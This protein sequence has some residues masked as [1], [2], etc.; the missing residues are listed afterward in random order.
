G[1][2][3]QGAFGAAWIAFWRYRV[4][5]RAEPVAAPL[6]DVG[7][8]IEQAVGTW[9]RMP[10]DFWSRLPASR[11]VGKRFGRSVAPWKEC[12]FNSTACGAFP[13]GF[14]RQTISA[15]REGAQPRAVLASFEPRYS[16]HWLLRMREIRLVKERRR[17]LALMAQKNRVIS[18]G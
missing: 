3:T 8:D 12:S 14:T 6:V 9:R 1:G 7:A 4:I 15:A 11:V 2:A 10:D 17:E 5:V 16:H 18:I 13:F